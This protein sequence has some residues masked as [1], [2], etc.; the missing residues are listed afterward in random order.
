MVLLRFY[1]GSTEVPTVGST[2]GSTEVLLRQQHS[3]LVEGLLD[4]VEVVE[5]I[6]HR[7]TD[8]VHS[9]R[10][11]QPLPGQQLVQ[12]MLDMRRTHDREL[13]AKLLD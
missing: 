4:L 10:S 8:G 2:V 6:L 11:R 1:C 9:M 13:S 3:Y 7:H 12:V 5:V